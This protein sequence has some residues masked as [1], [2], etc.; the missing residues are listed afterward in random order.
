MLSHFLYIYPLPSHTWCMHAG[1][2]SCW[3][4]SAQI[5]FDTGWAALHG[6]KLCYDDWFGW[7]SFWGVMLQMNSSPLLTFIR[8]H[9]SR[10]NTVYVAWISVFFDRSLVRSKYGT[11]LDH[12]VV[13]LVSRSD[14]GDL[15]CKAMLWYMLQSWA[16]NWSL[17]LLFHVLLFVVCETL[18]HHYC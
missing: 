18:L 3:F 10:W 12:H 1:Y 16:T 5:S 15:K 13:A 8:W 4:S 7:D 6:L 9:A 17:H 11:P 14:S 2:A